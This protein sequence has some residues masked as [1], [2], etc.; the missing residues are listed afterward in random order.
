MSGEVNDLIE[1]VSR[2]IDAHPYAK[3]PLRPALISLSLC[4]RLRG[5]FDDQEGLLLDRCAFYWLNGESD[6]S[7]VGLLET[8]YARLEGESETLSLSPSQE[9]KTRLL[10]SS[11]TVIGELDEETC[12]YLI[13]WAAMSGLTINE[14]EN[15]FQTYLRVT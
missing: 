1:N 3:D 7:R 8:L 12:G 11:I 15:A 14:I 5:R 2:L 9:A 6:E 13:S 10:I 4:H